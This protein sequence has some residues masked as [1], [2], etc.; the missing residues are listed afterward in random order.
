LWSTSGNGI[1]VED[2][3]FYRVFNGIGLTMI[4]STGIPSH[5]DGPRKI[6]ARNKIVLDQDDYTPNSPRQ[7]GILLAH[8]QGGSPSAASNSVLAMQT[9]EENTVSLL[10]SN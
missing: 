9:I 10:S 7:W 4:N 5:P 2:N 6:F 1:E 8:S 3:L